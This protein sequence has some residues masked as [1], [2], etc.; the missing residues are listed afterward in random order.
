MIFST[1][2]VWPPSFTLYDAST[3]AV[4]AVKDIGLNKRTVEPG[5]SFTSP[6]NPSYD[7]TRGGALSYQVASSMRACYTLRST[8]SPDVESSRAP[9]VL[10]VRASSIPI[11]TTFEENQPSNARK[12]FMIWYTVYT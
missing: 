7:S 12:L 8:A 10:R 6:V 3:R 4:S 2:I 5:I 11:V 9:A 1:A